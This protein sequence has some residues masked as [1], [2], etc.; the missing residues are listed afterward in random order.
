MNEETLL[1]RLYWSRI[2][3]RVLLATMMLDIPVAFAI[4]RYFNWEPRNVVPEIAAFQLF[5]LAGSIAVWWY[6]HHLL[7][8]N[9][10]L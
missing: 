8:Q 1:F 7:R 5:V 3:L 6:R 4:L 2:V 10:K 9:P